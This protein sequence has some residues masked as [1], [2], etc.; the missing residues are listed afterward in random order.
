MRPTSATGTSGFT[1]IELLA[2]VIIVGIVLALASVN[3]FPAD[4]EVARRETGFLAL[5]LEGARDDAWFGG[6]PV[7]VSVDDGQLRYW[8]LRGDRRWEPDA[9]R[10]SAVGEGLKVTALHWDG[11]ALAANDKII[12][13]PDGLGIAFRMAVE[14][15]GIARAIEGDPAG[16]IRVAP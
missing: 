12:F 11:E 10:G 3:L 7:A 16:A 15:R 5:K 6:R 1:L 9:A 8:K 2:V 14:V 4:E 13:L